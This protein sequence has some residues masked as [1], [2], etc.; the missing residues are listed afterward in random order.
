MEVNPLVLFNVK[1]GI[2][3]ETRRGNGLHLDLTWGT[4]SYFAFLR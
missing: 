2:A 3:M 1:H 4:P